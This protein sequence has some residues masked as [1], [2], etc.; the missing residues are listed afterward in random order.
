[1]FSFVFHLFIPCVFVF[2]NTFSMVV[3]VWVLEMQQ[4]RCTDHGYQGSSF[5][6]DGQLSWKQSTFSFLSVWLTLTC[7]KTW[8]VEAALYKSGASSFPTHTNFHGASNQ[9]QVGNCD[10]LWE[11]YKG[12]RSQFT[13]KD[14]WPLRLSISSQNLFLSFEEDPK[15]YW[16]VPKG[17][18]CKRSNKKGEPFCRVNIFCWLKGEV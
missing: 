7:C 14:S 18:S 12:L 4:D 16:S 10:L 8:V 5:L 11:F 6:G 9:E 3:T 2:K 13:M 17:Q 1:M 15:M